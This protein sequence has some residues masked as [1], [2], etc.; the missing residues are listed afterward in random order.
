MS[1]H[2]FLVSVVLLVFAAM[3]ARAAP[4]DKDCTQNFYQHKD[5]QCITT[6][7]KQLNSR[8]IAD[9]TG[10]I[11]PALIG[12]FA[13]IFSSDAALTSVILDKTASM[14]SAPLFIAALDKAGLA[15]Q[16]ETYAAS[17][18]HQEF[19]AAMRDKKT[20]PLSE[21][22]PRNSPADNDYLI[23]AYSAS[24]DIAYI[25]KIL[26]NFTAVAPQ[27]AADAL[28]VSMVM[29]KFG[30]TFSPPDRTSEIMQFAC[31][32][33]EC[34]KDRADLM[35]LLTLSSAFWA[36]NSL[37]VNDAAIKTSLTETFVDDARLKNI[38][39]AENVAF[40][41]YL[42]SIT[43]LAAFPDNADAKATVAAFE[44]LKPAATLVIPPMKDTQAQ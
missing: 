6:V 13:R 39:A 25:K 43:L 10:A 7:I 18:G 16:A 28:R 3:P 24:G 20:T 32:R 42:V 5:A 14:K 34:K 30:P 29:N 33:Y 19:Y 21:V 1:F 26:G 4:A 38:L 37:A 27:M 44:S 35:R 40:S 17:S 2:A 22:T 41:N 31:A 23:G 8:G 11:N 15:Q 36:L 12:F 9:D